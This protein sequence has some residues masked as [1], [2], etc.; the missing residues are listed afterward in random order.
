MNLDF[1]NH[2]FFFIC[3]PLGSGGQHFGNLVSLDRSFCPVGYDSHN[4]YIVAVNSEYDNISRKDAHV[5]L[6]KSI[7]IFKTE[8]FLKNLSLIGNNYNKSIWPM[9]LS[10]LNC[11]DDD[12]ML[13]KS[14]RK[15][16]M[17]VFTFRTELSRNFLKVRLSKLIGKTI[18]NDMFAWGIFD[19]QIFYSREYIMKTFDFK[20]Q[21]IY[22]IEISQLFNENISHLL[23]DL[24]KSFDLN[25]PLMESEALHRKWLKNIVKL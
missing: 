1:Y 17:I 16:R 9:H 20:D 3:Y 15:K 25:I 21:D 11:F 19:T 6:S 18:D 12:G 7:E 8:K 10:Y 22:E 23:A 2:D 14:M 13:F 24:N 5:A 4:D